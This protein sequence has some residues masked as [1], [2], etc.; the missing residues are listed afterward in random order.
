MANQICVPRHLDLPTAYHSKYN[1]KHLFNE[2][3]NLSYPLGI[4]FFIDIIKIPVKQHNIV[5][6]LPFGSEKV[7]DIKAGQEAITYAPNGNF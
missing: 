3:I 7:K 6:Y 1:V 2:T 4:Y 5:F